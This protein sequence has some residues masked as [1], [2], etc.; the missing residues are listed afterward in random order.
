MT[1]LRKQDAQSEK[2]VAA[3]LDRYFYP[4]HVTDFQR[5]ENKTTQLKGVDVC[6]NYGEKR[7][8]VDEKAAVHYVNKNLPTFAFELEFIGRDQQRHA[9]WLFD[10]DKLTEYYLLAWIWADQP[11][12]F[13][14]EDITKI[15]LLLVARKAIKDL[16]AKFQLDAKKGKEVADYLRKHQQFGVAGKSPNPFYYY[17]TKHLAEQPINVIIR[18]SALQQISQLGVTVEVE[19]KA[20]YTYKTKSTPRSTIS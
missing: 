4:A 5:I 19:R 15:D 13:T 16:L 7:M 9:G 1:T 17:H 6:F 8:L 11:K 2:A 14:T 20:S 12:H 10:E 18:K 3:F